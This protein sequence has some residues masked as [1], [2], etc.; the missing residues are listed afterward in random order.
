MAPLKLTYCTGR[1]ENYYPTLVEYWPMNE[2]GKF[3]I[4]LIRD[5]CN[6]LLLF[7]VKQ[8]FFGWNELVEEKS[9]TLQLASLWKGSYSV[10]TDIL[11][12]AN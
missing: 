7:F 4:L 8:S 10:F 12:Y 2:Q 1:F 11:Y 5:T 3:N 6:T 9:F